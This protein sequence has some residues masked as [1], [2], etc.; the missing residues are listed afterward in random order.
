MIPFADVQLMA[1]DNKVIEQG[2]EAYKQA[3][4]KYVFYK[5]Q[6]FDNVISWKYIANDEAYI[7]KGYGRN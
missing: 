2:R 4:S 5:E 3:I 7:V 1:L 6:G